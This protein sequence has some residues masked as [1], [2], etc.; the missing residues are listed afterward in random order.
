VLIANVMYACGYKFVVS[1]STP[2]MLLLTNFVSSLSKAALGEAVQNHIDMLRVFGYNSRVI[3]VDPLKA[4]VA[5]K[6]SFPGIEVD[7]SG[8]GDHLPIVD[9]RIR[10]LKEIGRS[11]IQ[12]L[13]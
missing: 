4:L 9:I 11:C 3:K 10:R 2:K 7:V 13:D 8:A 6:G 1:V 5:L 12:G